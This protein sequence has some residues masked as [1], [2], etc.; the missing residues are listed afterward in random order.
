MWLH[1]A[2]QILDVNYFGMLLAHAVG[3]K[4]I[5]TNVQYWLHAGGSYVS[6]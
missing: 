5:I 1:I 2:R 6:S 3:D 4:P